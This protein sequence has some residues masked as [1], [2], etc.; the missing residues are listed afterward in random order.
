MTDTARTIHTDADATVPED[1]R[2]V[3]SDAP[4]KPTGPPE[5]PYGYTDKGVPRKGPYRARPGRKRASKP[6]AGKSKAKASTDYRDAL[7][8]AL[9]VAM[10][11]L[12]VLGARPGNEVFLA[13]V[14]AI[15]AHAGP[16]IEALNDL[17]QDNAVL[18]RV[19]ER[20]GAIGPYGALIAAVTPLV[21]QLA[22][23]HRVAPLEVTRPMGAEAPEV[24]LAR[25]RAMTGAPPSPPAPP[26]SD[27][28]SDAEASAAWA[29]RHD[30]T[31]PAV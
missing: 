16:V 21:A 24:M 26:A 25:F 7:G 12:G 29:R 13:D 18:A 6:A 3:P 4:P 9:Q 23:N 2:D 15:D 28:P 5:A 17:A 8:G 20:I 10:V 11:P 27:R 1:R 31:A 14:V 22:T 19:F 30:R